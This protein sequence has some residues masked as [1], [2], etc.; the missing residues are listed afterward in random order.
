MRLH[1]GV[2]Q[3]LRCGLTKKAPAAQVAHAV[4]P[5]ADD[6]PPPQL[7]QKDEPVVGA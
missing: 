4:A 7:A 3:G 6:A 5:D 1:A 2:M